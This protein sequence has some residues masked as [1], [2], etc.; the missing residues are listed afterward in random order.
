MR[1]TYPN[2]AKAISAD[3]RSN[4]GRPLSEMLMLEP[5]SMEASLANLV[6]KELRMSGRK[7]TRA[8]IAVT[9]GTLYNIFKRK[10]QRRTV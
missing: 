8:E 6:S 3:S 4:G 1:K 10:Y 9:R 7:K 5:G 2:V